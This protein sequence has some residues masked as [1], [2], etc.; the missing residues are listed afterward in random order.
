M[1]EF[2]ATDGAFMA[3]ALQLAARGRYTVRPNPMVGC[4]LVRDGEVVGEGWHKKAGE[5]HAEI[6]AMTAAGAV[7]GATAYITLEPCSHHGRTPPCA[8]ALVD[9]QLADVVVAMRDPFADVSGQGIARLEN[10]GIRVRTG[11]MDAAARSLNRGYL[12]RVETG[13]PFVRL[14]MA[15]SIDGA[16]AMQNGES[17]WITGGEARDDVQRLRAE[18]GA[19]LSGIGTVLADDPSFTVRSPALDTGGMQPLRVIVDTAL[20]MPQSAS[21]LCLD[22]DTLVFCVDDS[23]RVVLE[24][25]GAEVVRVECSDGKVDLAGVLDELGARHINDV[26]VEAGPGLAGSLL[27]QNLVDELVIYQAPHIMGSQTISMFETPGWARLAD[28]CSIEI[29]DTR[30]VGLDT[31]ITA[32]LAD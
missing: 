13:R 25:L 14:K 3:R 29:T 32:K 18:S 26:L 4:V 5:P 19:I 27:A 21:M 12:S 2:T 31:R 11:L 6:N 22:G 7:E 20:R 28:R 30:R 9:A 8:D 17:Q 10:A 16:V 15:T 23:N 1:S 24:D